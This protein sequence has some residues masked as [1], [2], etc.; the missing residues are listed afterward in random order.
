MKIFRR[1][2]A[3]NEPTP[4]MQPSSN[5]RA[6]SHLQPQDPKVPSGCSRHQGGIWSRDSLVIPAAGIAVKKQDM[7]RFHSLGKAQSTQSCLFLLPGASSPSQD[8]PGWFGFTSA[9]P[10]QLLLSLRYLLPKQHLHFGMR[11]SKPNPRKAGD[12]GSRITPRIQIQRRT[13][14]IHTQ[15]H[16]NE[17]MG[18]PRAG[19]GQDLSS[20]Q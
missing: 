19:N 4:G 17:L 14:V 18:T 11:K 8:I 10:W 13:N 5:S 7:S 1:A 9:L 16:E 12:T 20:L 2:Q 15:E 3:R 6:G